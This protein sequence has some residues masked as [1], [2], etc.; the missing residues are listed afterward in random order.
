MQRRPIYTGATNDAYDQS[1]PLP[2]PA[3]H[4]RRRRGGGRA[5]RLPRR[6]G[7]GRPRGRRRRPRAGAHARRRG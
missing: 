2:T 5:C 3:A 4:R 1:E 6:I 7:D